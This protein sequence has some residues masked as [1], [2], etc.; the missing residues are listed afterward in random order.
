MFWIS[1]LVFYR[2]RVRSG[3]LFAAYLGT[4]M[5]RLISM[6]VRFKLCGFLFS[7][8]FTVCGF[9]FPMVFISK[10]FLSL[11]ENVH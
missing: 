11:F 1:L 7:K 9:L 2:F 4:V 10:N 6:I 8:E 5:H 3:M